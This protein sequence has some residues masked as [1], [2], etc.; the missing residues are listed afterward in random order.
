MMQKQAV[1]LVLLRVHVVPALPC[2]A[3]PC[4]ALFHPDTDALT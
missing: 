1:R 4:P 2:R 3:L